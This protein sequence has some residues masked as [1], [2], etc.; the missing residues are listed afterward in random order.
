MEGFQD[1]PSAEYLSIDSLYQPDLFVFSTRDDDG[2]CVKG[3]GEGREDWGGGGAL[4]RKFCAACL[5]RCLGV[6]DAVGVPRERALGVW[7]VG[8]HFLWL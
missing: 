2:E 5:R 3:Q 1:S 6:V 4:Q 8:G 7:A